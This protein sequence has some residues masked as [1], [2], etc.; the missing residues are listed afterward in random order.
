MTSATMKPPR[1]AY[2]WKTRTSVIYFIE[3]TLTGRRYIGSAAIWER[4]KPQHLWDLRNNRHR[5]KRLQRAWNKYGEKAFV[6]GVLET[7]EPATSPEQLMKREQFWIDKTP[8][9]FNSGPCS[10]S[11]LGVKCSATTRRRMSAAAVIRNAKRGDEIIH[12]LR[13]AS[14]KAAALTTAV[15]R[16]EEVKRKISSAKLG[17]AVSDDTRRKLSEANKNPVRLTVDQARGII[18]DLKE[19]RLSQREIA[20]KYG[21]KYWKVSAIH[22]RRAWRHLWAEVDGGD[23]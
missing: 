13:R 4:R 14:K 22:G 10:K 15:P 1:S 16:P 19:Q 21:V 18:R 17:H 12:T 9:R 6:F 3:L 20:N 2:R 5:N 11:R 8:L 7:L 23:A